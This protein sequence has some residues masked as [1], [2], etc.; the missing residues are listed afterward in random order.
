MNKFDVIIIG[1]GIAGLSAALTSVRNGMRTALVERENYAGG[2]AKDCFHTYICGMFK[3]DV[4]SPFQLANAGICSEIFHFISNCHGEK[5]LVKMGKIELLA[6]IPEDL[7]GYFFKNFNRQNFCFFKNTRCTDIVSKGR[8]IRKIKILSDR[9][10]EKYAGEKDVYLEGGVFIDASGCSFSAADHGGNFSDNSQLGGYCALLKGR[11][12]KNL[13]LLIPYTAGKIVK[14]YKLAEYLRFVNMTR[15]FLTQSYIL[16]FAVRYQEDKKKCKFIYKKL[17]ENIEEL[18]DLTLI[19]FSDQI[20]FR[21]CNKIHDSSESADYHNNNQHNTDTYHA[22]CHDD[23]SVMESRISKDKEDNKKVICAADSDNV[24]C[25]ADTDADCV[26]KSFW[27]VETWDVEKG[28]VYRYC[29]ENIPFCVP[30]SALK[31]EN[32]DNLFLAG[33]SIRV[34]DDIHASA[35]VMGVCMATGEKASVTAYKYLKKEII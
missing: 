16:K 12:N 21:A 17:N 27:P 19:R 35:R 2:I 13:S 28:P 32:F 8:K 7:W 33:K 11:L 9:S 23:A 24:I 1:A 18:A 14:K 3:N 22:D 6:F 20:H 4:K 31:D 15:N 25:A 30:A 26:V 29:R 5:C 34:P 10:A